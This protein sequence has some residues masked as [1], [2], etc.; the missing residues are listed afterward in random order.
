MGNSDMVLKE[1]LEK[2][3]PAGASSLGLHYLP[4][5][6]SRRKSENEMNLSGMSLQEEV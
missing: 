6:D 3:S 2:D 4:F 1:A 5:V